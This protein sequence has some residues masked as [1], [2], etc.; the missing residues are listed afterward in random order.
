MPSRSRSSRTRIAV[1]A[2]HRMVAAH[3]VHRDGDFPIGPLAAEL[4]DDLHWAR[5][6]ILRIASASHPVHTQLGVA[7]ALISKPLGSFRLTR[8]KHALINLIFPN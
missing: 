5:M 3:S 1:Q 7:A 6:A 2:L 4:S 8:T